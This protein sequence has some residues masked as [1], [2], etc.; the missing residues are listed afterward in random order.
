MP[1]RLDPGTDLVLNLHFQPSVKA[2]GIQASIGLYFTPDPPKRF[3]MLVQLEHDGALDIPS[4][5]KDFTV[6]DHLKLPVPVEVLA[7]YPHAHY[8]GKRVEA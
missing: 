5:A 1:W 3:P 8:L 7:I 6:T 4:G 2:E